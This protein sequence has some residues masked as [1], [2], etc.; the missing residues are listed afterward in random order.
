MATGTI[1]VNWGQIPGFPFARWRTGTRGLKIFSQKN[2]PGKQEEKLQSLLA[3]HFG[4]IQTLFSW[5][6]AKEVFTLTQAS[7]LA[8]QR[9][10]VWT[11]DKRI[12]QEKNNDLTT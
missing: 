10:A 3:Y 12:K 6:C 4:R 5:W 9:P 8:C 11:R 1:G 7:G 2:L